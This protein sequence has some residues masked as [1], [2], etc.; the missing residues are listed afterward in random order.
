MDLAINLLTPYNS[1]FIYA[2][3][4]ISIQPPVIRYDYGRSIS[5]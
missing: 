2:Y 5:L 1:M 3:K 4:Y